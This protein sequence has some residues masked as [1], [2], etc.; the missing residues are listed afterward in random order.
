LQHEKARSPSVLLR[1]RVR[2]RCGG[3][4]L[5]QNRPEKPP[6]TK[7][8]HGEARLPFSRIHREIA[9]CNLTLRCEFSARGSFVF[10]PD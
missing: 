8:A 9:S 10:A 7:T 4:R 3:S 2:L 6:G 5:R 1:E